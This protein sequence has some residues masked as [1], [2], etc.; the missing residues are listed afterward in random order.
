VTKRDE[1]SRACHLIQRGQ[2]LRDAHI[3]HADLAQNFQLFFF[4]V[5]S[6]KGVSG[7]EAAAARKVQMSQGRRIAHQHHKARDGLSHRHVVGA[8]NF[9][10]PE[11]QHQ[12]RN[13]FRQ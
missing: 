2:A 3:G 6:L 13:K 5:K 8:R 7:F 12:Q 1:T 10:E 11:M 9:E 4:L